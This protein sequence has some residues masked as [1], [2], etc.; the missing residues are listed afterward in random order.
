MVKLTR[1]SIVIHLINPTIS[2]HAQSK[3]SML[4]S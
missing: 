3:C 1:K 4:K 2:A